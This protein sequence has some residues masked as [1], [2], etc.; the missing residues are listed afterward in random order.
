M[1]IQQIVGKSAIV[2]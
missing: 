1:T 2:F